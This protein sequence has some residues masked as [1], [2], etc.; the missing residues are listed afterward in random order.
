MNRLLAIGNLKNK[1]QMGDLKVHLKT[2]MVKRKVLL[3]QDLKA[4]SKFGIKTLEKN[5]RKL[6]IYDS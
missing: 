1:S 4:N 3:L 5:Q 2:W 6:I